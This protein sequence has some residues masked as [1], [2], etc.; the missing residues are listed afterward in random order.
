MLPNLEK[1]L[2]PALNPGEL[3]VRIDRVAPDADAGRVIGAI[4]LGL[5]AIEA[6]YKLPLIPGKNP[7]PAECALAE[8]RGAEDSANEIRVSGL[9]HMIL[10]FFFF[11]FFFSVGNKDKING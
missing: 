11:M 1:K 7:P 9:R 10:F 5:A 2:R 3:E 6:I 4:G 8:A